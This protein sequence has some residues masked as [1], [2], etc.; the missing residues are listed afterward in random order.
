MINVLGNV[1]V[2]C[3]FAPSVNAQ[4]SLGGPDIPSDVRRKTANDMTDNLLRRLTDTSSIWVSNPP[5]ADRL[6]R[7]S[8]KSH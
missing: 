5:W 1:F 2:G 8:S 4:T 7:V 6:R 3:E